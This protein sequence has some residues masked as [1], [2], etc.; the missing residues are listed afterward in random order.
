LYSNSPGR[1]HTNI[2]IF[3]IFFETFPGSLSGEV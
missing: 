3:F 2:F 1:V